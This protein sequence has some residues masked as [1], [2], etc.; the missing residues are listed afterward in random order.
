MLTFILMAIVVG[1]IIGIVARLIVPGRQNMS[2]ALTVGVGIV[3]AV[4]GAFIGR[5]A[6]L[7]TVVTLI[8]EVAIAAVLVWLVAGR[9]RSTR[10]VH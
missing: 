3:G 2:A 7:S 6:H 5:A 4:V 8:V 9:S 1:A 10:N